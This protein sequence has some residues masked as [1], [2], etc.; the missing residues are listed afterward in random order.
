MVSPISKNS[1]T[2]SYATAQYNAAKPN[3][4]GKKKYRVVKGDNLWNIAKTHIQKNNAKKS[5][6]SNFMYEIAKLNKKST[7]KAMNNL[8][9]NEVLYI[10]NNNNSKI[11]KAQPKTNTAKTTK[12]TP[13]NS[14]TSASKNTT[15][16][17]IAKKQ[18][19][20]LTGINYLQ[21]SKEINKILTHPNSR[22][23]YTEKMIYKRN[24]IKKIPPKLYLAHGKAGIDYWTKTTAGKNAENKFFYEKN[25]S[26]DGKPSALI[27]SKREGNNCQGNIQAEIYVNV[28]DKGKV[29][30]FSYNTPGVN[31]NDIAFDYKVS[32]NGKMEKPTDYGYYNTIATL[33]KTTVAKLTNNLQ[34]IIDKKL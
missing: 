1:K 7:I 19:T 11:A 12:Q 25:Y 17:Q 8:K 27:I 14:K 9:V 24:Q 22:V 28:N 2:G 5:E 6:I 31:I 32:T 4:K 21:T 33:P 29:T 23:N 13:I 30:S 10:P 26:Y 3:E 18:I 16:P 20:P 15:K 34:H